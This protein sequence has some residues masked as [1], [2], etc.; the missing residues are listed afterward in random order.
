MIQVKEAQRLILENTRVLDSIEIP[1]AEAEG[2]V[3]SEDIVSTVN[4][5][6]F[7]NSA[8]D[9]YAVKS[10]D[11][12]GASESSPILLK[13]TGLVRAGDYP[14]L[15][16][17]DGEAVKIMTGASLPRGA[18]S[19]VMVEYTEGGEGVVNV[20]R[21]VGEGENVRYEGEEI[22]K[23]EIALQSGTL[24]NPAS[25][26][27][28]AEFG[29]K[30]V[31]VYRKP[32]VAM[33]VTGEEVVGL[34]EDLE[35]GKIRDTN[36]VTLQSALSR[37]K[38]EPLFIGRARDEISDIR[39]KLEKGLSLSDVIIVTGGVSVGD[40]DYVKDVLEGLGVQPVFW[41]VAQ[42]PG[43]PLFFGKKGDKL[44]FGLPGNPASALVCF[45]EYVR[46]ALQR[47]IGKKEVFLMEVEA[48]L[49]EEMKKKPDGKTHF[50]RGHLEKRGDSFYAKPTGTQGSHILKSFALSNCLI[51]FSGDS[52][53][54]PP[55]SKVEVHILP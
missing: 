53:H 15:V 4:L 20:K 38:A 23:G 31:R 43:G 8:M 54:L 28:I 39:E 52:T 16:L 1:L 5:P 9:G 29:I 55:G 48:V 3:L 14:E 30:K 27:F 19:V 2:L 47:R 24:L 17:G 21:G 51:V 36:S 6:Y 26:G 34:D 22:K 37:E 45:Y 11:T 40:Y 44:V 12:K 41:R 25:I 33:V 32:R 10:R 7:T 50:I 13:V 49:L 35:P 18:D 42:R 46:P